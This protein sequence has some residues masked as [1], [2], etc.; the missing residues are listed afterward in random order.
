[1]TAAILIG[2]AGLVV[3]VIGGGSVLGW[4]ERRNARRKEVTTRIHGELRGTYLAA[5]KELEAIQVA[6]DKLNGRVPFDQQK[7]HSVGLPQHAEETGQLLRSR[8]DLHSTVGAQVTLL[9]AV[10]SSLWHRTPLDFDERSLAHS[11]GQA[12]REPTSEHNDELAHLM[13]R[14]AQQWASVTVRQFNE[15]ELLRGDSVIPW[16][17]QG[18]ATWWD[19][20]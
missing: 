10:L 6:V 20:L 11:L 16:I 4:R 3:T 5:H 9:D 19:N 2:L 8:P 15:L 7:L 17:R 13:V 14:G 12:S 18:M 1:M